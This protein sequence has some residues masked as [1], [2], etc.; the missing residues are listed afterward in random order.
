MNEDWRAGDLA[1]CIDDNW[2]DCPPT[3]PSLGDLLRVTGV[4]DATNIVHNVRVYALTF[5]GLGGYFATTGFRKVRPDV[6]AAE[7]EFTALIKRLGK[8][9]ARAK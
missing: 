4:Y 1:V 2:V 8:S 7:T 5:V 9:P 3:A 6:T